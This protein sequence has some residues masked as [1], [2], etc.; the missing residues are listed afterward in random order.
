MSSYRSSALTITDARFT[1]TTQ[2]DGPPPRAVASSM[3]LH[4]RDANP[5]DLSGTRTEVEPRRRADDRSATPDRGQILKS[6]FQML[7]T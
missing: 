4:L 6:T 7:I 5:T 3:R 1:S 2:A